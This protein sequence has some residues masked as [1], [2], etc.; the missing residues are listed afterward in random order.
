M[1]DTLRRDIKI[2][3]FCL[4]TNFK[5]VFNFIIRIFMIKTLSEMSNDNTA[6]QNIAD[7]TIYKL[8]YF[9]KNIDCKNELIL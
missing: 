2:F 8:D 7:T 6:L 1:Q 3:L 4:V 9:E 5:S